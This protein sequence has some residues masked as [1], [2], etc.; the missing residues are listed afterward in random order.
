[1][2]MSKIFSLLLPRMIILGF[3]LFCSK[4]YSEEKSFTYVNVNS[5]GEIQSEWSLHNHLLDQENDDN[6]KTFVSTRDVVDSE[7]ILNFCEESILCIVDGK[8]YLR[9]DKLLVHSGHY[10]LV[11]DLQQLI[12]LDEVFK[13]EFGYYIT[14]DEPRCLKGHLGFR[15]LLGIWYC[16]DRRC[17]YY[18]Y[19]N[20]R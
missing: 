18:Y 8:A 10:V 15:K 17:Q 6:S 3:L 11:N 13:D 4:G 1:M 5:V 19:N 16:L 20:W 7:S 9:P 12:R 2:F 14:V